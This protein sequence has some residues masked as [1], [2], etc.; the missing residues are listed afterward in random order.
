MEHNGQTR[1]NEMYKITSSSYRTRCFD[2]STTEL[3]FWAFSK[4]L[5]P[6]AILEWE[7]GRASSLAWNSDFA[8]WTPSSAKSLCQAFFNSSRFSCTMAIVRLILFQKTSSVKDSPH[9]WSTRLICVSRDFPF[10]KG[11]TRYLDASTIEGTPLLGGARG[12]LI[13]VDT[14][15]QTPRS[16][17]VH[18]LGK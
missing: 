12:W 8:W 10:S 3:F 1:W 17:S 16:R 14:S 13:D 9:L 7:R 11:S 15:A 18:D 2:K 6:S 5:C 4:V